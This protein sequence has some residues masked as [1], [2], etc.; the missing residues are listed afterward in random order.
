MGHIVSDEFDGEHQAHPPS[1]EGHPTVGTP[2]NWLQ[3]VI[4]GLLA[5]SALMIWAGMS[6]EESYADLRASI[7]DLDDANN[8]QA[9]GAP[10]QAVVNGWTTIEYLN[11]LST[12]QE[13]SDDRRDALILVGLVGGAAAIAT[14]RDKVTR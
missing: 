14:R 12:Q 13:Q 10:Q 8:Q 7:E 6:P 11:L 2:P 3:L 5:L 1:P 4:A 9:Q